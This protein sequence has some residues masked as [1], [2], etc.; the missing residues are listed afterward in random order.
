M[1]NHGPPGGRDAKAKTAA[2]DNHLV[3]G[4][5]ILM[6]AWNFFGSSVRLLTT[7]AAAALALL[8]GI[9]V[10]ALA[11][12]PPPQNVVGPTAC[13]QC[14]KNEAIV[15]QQTHHFTTFHDLPRMQK[16][17]DITQKLGIKRIK[18]EPLCLSCHFTQAVKDGEV[19]PVSGISCESCHGPGAPYIK[20]H[21][22]FS[23]KKQDTETAAERDQ[24]WADS[25]AAGMIRPSMLY[26][27]AKNCYSCHIVPQE[28][29][30]NVGGHPLS[31]FELVSWTQ[32]EIRHNVWYTGGKSNPE[33][34]QNVKRKMYVVGAAVE[35]EESLR[36]VGKATENATYATTMAQ[37][38]QAAAQRLN[39]ISQALKLPET[40]AMMQ[41]V[42]SAHLR[43]N[44][45]AELSGLA[46]SIGAAT[47]QF[48]TNYDGSSLG[49]IDS[50]IPGPDQYKGKPLE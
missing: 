11:A 13:A 2:N 40:D 1:H 23:G 39:A 36:A 26:E 30:I 21:A 44:N 4:V 47:K 29:L 42:R 12:E 50:M 28:R 43:L 5:D 16:A 37:R 10:A 7:G 9:S 19:Q 34:S 48:V 18:T 20:L 8:L 6:R 22:S 24:R 25:V 3:R 15:W 27:L 17:Q 35:L 38:A 14:H 41:S 46:A 31:P 33:A 32:G 49:A 45:D